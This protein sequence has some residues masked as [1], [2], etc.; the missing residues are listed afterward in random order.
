M[1]KRRKKDVNT[2]SARGPASLTKAL[3]LRSSQVRLNDH[4]HCIRNFSAL[5]IQNFISLSFTL[6]KLQNFIFNNLIYVTHLISQI[7]YNDVTHFP[8]VPHVGRQMR[9][10]IFLHPNNN[11]NLG[12]NSRG[13]KSRGKNSRE[14]KAEGKNSRWKKRPTEKKA[15]G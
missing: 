10:N 8:T 9:Q 7:C 11:S 15:D 4:E 12:K 6:W 2:R 1:K 14:K 3:C 5:N 13:K